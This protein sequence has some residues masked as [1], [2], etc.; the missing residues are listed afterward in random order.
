MSQR[1]W[2]RGLRGG[3]GVTASD[4]TACACYGA[5]H[6]NNITNVYIRLHFK[7]GWSKQTADASMFIENQY[8]VYVTNLQKF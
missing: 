7:A 5:D 6:Y 8:F 4:Q 3:R 2:V 1:F